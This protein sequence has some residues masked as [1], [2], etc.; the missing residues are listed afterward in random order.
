VGSDG[1]FDGVRVTGCRIRLGASSE[2][3]RAAL[4]IVGDQCRPCGS[5]FA[6]QQLALMRARTKARADMDGAVTAAAYADWLA[7]YPPDVA[8]QA[9][10]EWARGMVFWP[11]WAELQRICDRLI[12]ARLE[13]RRELRRVLDARSS[14]QTQ[15]VAMPR[16]QSMGGR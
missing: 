3:L 12:S 4:S 11:A 10:E 15:A 7:E 8:R 5:D 16:L 1:Q 9:C 14:G 2:D 6:L 13:L